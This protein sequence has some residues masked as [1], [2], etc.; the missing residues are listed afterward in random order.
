MHDPEK[1]RKRMLEARNR[2]N[3]GVAKERFNEE[4]KEET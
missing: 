4:V 2:K 3:I 1:I